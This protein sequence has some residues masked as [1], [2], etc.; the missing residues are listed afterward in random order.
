M[1]QG[2]YDFRLEVLEGVAATLLGMA[3]EH[4]E[5]AQRLYSEAR[6]AQSLAADGWIVEQVR[7]A[8]SL[9]SGHPDQFRVMSGDLRGRVDILK[10]LSD[11]WQGT[12]K[13]LAVQYKSVMSAEVGLLE[14]VGH[15]AFRVVDPVLAGTAEVA[16]LIAGAVA[17]AAG[18]NKLLTANKAGQAD[19]AKANQAAQNGRKR[20]ALQSTTA[21]QLVA[22]NLAG[23]RTVP[24]E[25][26]FGSSYKDGS[27]TQDD[28]RDWDTGG[29]NC[30]PASLAMVINFFEKR[31]PGH[32]LTPLEAANV[33]RGG[34][35]NNNTA[36]N[37]WTG[38]GD[39]KDLLGQ[40]HLQMANSDRV[41]DLKS[42]KAQ[43][44]SGHPV[45]IRVLNDEYAGA[46]KSGDTHDP[47]LYSGL[48]GVLSSHVIV[49]TGYELEANG[50]IQRVCINDPLSGYDAKNP[51]SPAPMQSFQITASEFQ[52]AASEIRNDKGLIVQVGWEGVGVSPVIDPKK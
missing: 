43:L 30:G 26:Q 2:K 17:T 22:N 9:L 31:P 29:D 41:T 25:S 27:S 28:N 50:D 49:V 16:A 35:S 21:A 3:G 13:N 18:A 40:H 8:A 5:M 7:Y 15:A 39:Y 10:A 19:D 37:K 36:V 4:E 38:F 14:S 42:L 46:G 32:E 34:A 12:Q 48:S 1:S 6:A 51:K 33:V 24:A 23:L 20:A 44:D 11:V 45:V 47:K 52:N